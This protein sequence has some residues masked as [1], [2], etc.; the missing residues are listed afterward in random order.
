MQSGEPSNSE[1]QGGPDSWFVGSNKKKQSV[2]VSLHWCL[3]RERHYLAELELHVMF[4][5]TRATELICTS[6]YATDV[7]GCRVY[8]ARVPQRNR[9]LL[10]AAYP[11]RS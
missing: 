10:E 5:S 2:R 8:A 4:D 3:C 6:S 7:D 9:S 1:Q 11:D